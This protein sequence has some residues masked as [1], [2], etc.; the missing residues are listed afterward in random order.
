MV[1]FPRHRES[2]IGR[3]VAA[4]CASLLVLFSVFACSSE[5]SSETLVEK[6]GQ[7]E[8]AG[9]K[10]DNENRPVAAGK[11]AEE[12]VRMYL[13]ASEKGDMEAVFRLMTDEAKKASSSWE[14]FKQKECQATEEFVVGEA[15]VEDDLARVP[16]IITGSSGSEP[17]RE[18]TFLLR[19]SD[20]L[21]G[22]YALESVLEDGSKF[23]LN[24]EKMDEMAKKMEGAFRQTVS[25]DSETM[26]K[27]AEVQQKSFDGLREISP[28]Q[29]EAA[30]KTD[31]IVEKR[32]AGEVLAELLAPMGVL[33]PSDTG[34]GLLDTPVSVSLKGKSR[35]E[36]IEAVCA[37]LGH[38]PE[39]PQTPEMLYGVMGGFVEAFAKSVGEMAEGEGESHASNA[40]VLIE[41]A[42]PRPAIFFGPLMMVVREIEQKPAYATGYLSLTVFGADIDQGVFE[43]LGETDDPFQVETLEDQ[44]DNS[45]F[46]SITHGMR[47]SPYGQ[48]AFFRL[49]RTVHLKNLLR[50]VAGIREFSGKIV[51]QLP[52]AILQG[53]FRFE[54]DGEKMAESLGPLSVVSWR[55]DK[56]I[57]VEFHGPS[58]VLGN[59]LVKYAP[60]DARGE[61]VSVSTTGHNWAIVEGSDQP[62]EVSAQLS[63]SRPAASV[64]CKYVS[65]VEN[66]EIPFSVKSLALPSPELM[67]EALPPLEHPGFDEPVSLE[68]VELDRSDPYFAKAR[69]RIAS[70][71]NKDISR[72]EAKFV[73]LDDQK[74]E[75]NEFPHRLEGAETPEGQE[76][77]VAAGQTEEKQVTAFFIP[78]NMAGATFRI[79]RV[80]FMDASVWEP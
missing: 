28:E 80:E 62:G 50:H 67:P 73:Y 5:K 7:V 29:F 72:I 8:G 56:E 43:L 63:L 32:P 25:P 78:E 18:S 24:F 69:I 17:P 52:A 26:R 2:G 39:Y 20:G 33:P 12:I 61:P 11:S 70:H 10:I 51:F 37:Q 4:I 55:K 53:E 1:S 60:A 3:K 57:F 41:G 49:D 15:T 40:L 79:D 34:D 36:S 46:R 35:L 13:E 21:W 22:I 75:I 65:R 71:S 38:Y 77:Y 48:G 30:W 66:V 44:R 74:N 19:S 31:L 68:F 54:N 59:R 64:A 14:Q 47:F 45:L 76:L 23:I 9:K 58:S 16:V 42:R 6:S 27:D